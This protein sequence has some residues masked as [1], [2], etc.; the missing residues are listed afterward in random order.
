MALN[1]NAPFSPPI[2]HLMDNVGEVL[3]RLEDT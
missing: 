2:F 3:P 1:K